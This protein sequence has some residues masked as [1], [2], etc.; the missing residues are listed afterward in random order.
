MNQLSRIS[1]LSSFLLLAANLLFAQSDAP[2]TG[3]PDLSSFPPA[4]ITRNYLLMPSDLIEMRV[5]QE[6]DLNKQ[7]RIEADGT[8]MLPLINRVTVGGLTILEAQQ[9]IEQLY[10]R[11]FLVNPQINLLILEYRV[12]KIDVLGQVNQPGPVEIPHD[13][14]LTLVEAISRAGSFTR[15]AR[16]TA[17]QV[18]RIDDEG[19]KQVI[20]L[21][22]DRM[23]GSNDSA[24]FVLKDGDTIFVPERFL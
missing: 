1:F 14:A 2:E 10:D 18:T 15:L 17:V 11:D 6:P 8:I 23:M 16:R 20:E 5:F 7:V 9:L 13:K 3:E 12:R 24:D 21:N 22:V 4:P 19:R